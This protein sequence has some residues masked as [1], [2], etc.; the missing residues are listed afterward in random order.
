MDLKAN[1]QEVAKWA[2]RHAQTLGFSGSSIEAAYIWN[3]GG[4]VN[5]S[6]R[7]TDGETVRHL[8]LA[9][10][11]K[12]PELRQWARISGCLSDRY[13]AP[14]LVQ[15]V[16]QEIVPGYTCGLV[17][18]YLKGE[19]L[20]TAPDPLSVIEKV[21]PLISRL[22]ADEQIRQ[23]VPGTPE[24]QTLTYSDAFIQEYIGRFEED[25][26]GIKAG[27]QLL[28]FVSDTTM[29]WFD[30]EVGRLKKLVEEHPSFRKQA[31]DIVHNDLNWQNILVGEHGEHWMIDWDDLSVAGD[32]AMDYSVL[33][34]PLYRTADWPVWQERV[35]RLA[36]EDA[37]ERMEI[38]FRA[39]LL[40]DVIDVLADYVE[41][42]QIPDVK[43]V[44]Q[45]RARNIHLRAYPEYLKLYGT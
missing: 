31:A 33:L 3:P 45:E 25:L 36:G 20:S 2:A 15:E 39:K 17:F 1:E 23:A 26:E 11:D 28:S 6:Y 18:E 27:R 40:D 9:K 35:S 19:P 14:R 37:A 7:L 29:E 12:A 44:T 5:Q 16:A 43:E 8:K 42:E 22:H 30:A 13:R 41:A 38:Y 10:E 21:L 4:F 32:A 24:M 34:W